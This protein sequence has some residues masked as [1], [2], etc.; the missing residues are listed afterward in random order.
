MSVASAPSQLERACALLSGPSAPTDFF[1]STTVSLPD[2]AHGLRLVEVRPVR[3][4]LIEN[5]TAFLFF[6]GMLLV[7]LRLSWWWGLAAIVLYLGYHLITKVFGSM[8]DVIWNR[9]REPVVR[10]SATTLEP[11]G[12]LVMECELQAKSVAT[13]RGVTIGLMTRESD[14]ESK[15]TESHGEWT[16]VKAEEPRVIG[17][18]PVVVRQSLRAP[19]RVQQR[20]S[21]SDLSW[22]LTFRVEV[23]GGMTLRREYPIKLSG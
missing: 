18:A 6:V 14:G 1:T 13:I 3:S 16:L 4:S 5:A 2:I 10:L 20:W 19:L 17:T 23:D 22:R 7:V 15:T 11:G 9:L 21:G 12:C 8:D